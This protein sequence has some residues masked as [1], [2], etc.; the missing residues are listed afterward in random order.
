MSNTVADVDILLVTYNHEKYIRQALDSILCQ[1]FDGSY[2][3]VV[4]DDCSTDT[5]VSIIRE[6][7]DT[8]AHVA[9]FFLPNTSNLGIT[10]NYQ[11]GFAACSAK[12]VS[13]L[14][15]DDY[16]LTNSKLRKQCDFLD[17]NPGFI[18]CA[19]NH[20]NYNQ[21]NFSYYL[22]HKSRRGD[23][24]TITP[25]ELI[26]KNIIGNFSTSMYRLS[27]IQKVPPALYDLKSYDWIFNICMGMQG[28][29]AFLMEPLSVYRVHGGGNWS[30]LPE[31]KKLQDQIALIE[32]YDVLT[33]HVFHSDFETV[34]YHLNNAL[35]HETRQSQASMGRVA[36]L[37]YK[38]LC[39]PLLRRFLCVIG[40]V[41]GDLIPP[42]VP[43]LRRWFGLL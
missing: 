27:A 14:E 41:A 19:C 20:Y 42:F 15:G 17:R 43:K 34:K 11:R 28:M 30:G 23:Y 2:R 32:P 36:Y 4:A 3:I 25:Q 26:V 8:N 13:V 9:F 5:T 24:I 40:Q 6:Y 1:S 16:W 22:E 31:R 12:Y 38:N 7:A 21:D 10:R 18:F 37:I 29:I 35:G 39:P 33:N